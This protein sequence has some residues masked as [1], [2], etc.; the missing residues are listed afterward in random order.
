[1]LKA[2]ENNGATA[3]EI[4]TDAVHAPDLATVLR[5]ATQ[6]ALRQQ[7]LA[8]GTP[9]LPPWITRQPS[10]SPNDGEISTY[11][12]DAAALIATRMRALALDAAQRRPAWT[13]GLG[14]PPA[15]P[16][17]CTDWIRHI[18]IIAAY[19]D[20]HQIITDDPR[21]ILGPYAEPGHAGHTAYWHAAQSVLTAR[22]LA[23]LEP[24]ATTSPTDTQARAQLAA[25]IY[26]TLPASE[27]ATTQAAMISRLGGAWFGTTDETDDHAVTRPAYG[28]HLAAV[29]TERGHLTP[30]M[31]GQ[32][33]RTAK[34]PTISPAHYE[35]TSRPLEATFAQRRAAERADKQRRPK[36]APSSKQAPRHR[37]TI[38]L[39]TSQPQEP[40]PGWQPPPAQQRQPNHHLTP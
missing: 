31:A 32:P 17:Q 12:S 23:G 5:I 26:L 25:D 21:Q 34:E 30:Q 7:T 4:L 28:P 20:Q 36:H 40:A 29:L 18:G 19:R 27:R 37:Q 9:D 39:Q 3:E 13:S 10:A 33:S 2:A 6:A 24:P 1:M 15:D 11:I 22:R 35:Q 8:N 16:S 38:P 14:D